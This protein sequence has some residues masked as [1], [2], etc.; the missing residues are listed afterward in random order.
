MRF[1]AHFEM[2]IYDPAR[3]GWTSPTARVDEFIG[4][5]DLNGGKGLD[6]PPLNLT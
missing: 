5:I 3:E 6:K 4:A 1:R 2:Q